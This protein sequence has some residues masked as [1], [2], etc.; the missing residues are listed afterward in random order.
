MYDEY[1][2]VFVAPDGRM[3]AH[4]KDVLLSLVNQAIAHR[5]A[6]RR[7]ITVNPADV[8]MG[9]AAVASLDVHSIH[10][11]RAGGQEALRR[12]VTV[13]L[14]MDSVKTAVV[15]EALAVYQGPIPSGD[16]T[17]SILE[18]QL[19]SAWLAAERACS[20]ITVFD[21]SLGVPSTTPSSD[22]QSD[23]RSP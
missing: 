19:W 22:C 16:R 5:E 15:Q 9:L 2:L 3:D 20:N 13:F 7:G 8:E 12:R 21:P 14:E 6:A 11:D 1:A 10:I 4:P 18:E 17:G 23:R